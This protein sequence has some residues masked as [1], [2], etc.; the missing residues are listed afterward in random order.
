MAENINIISSTTTNNLDPQVPNDNF[1]MNIFLTAILQD[2]VVLNHLT[3]NWAGAQSRPGLLPPIRH[4]ITTAVENFPVIPP[5]A[6][7]RTSSRDSGR[8][9][10]S[11]SRV[12][13]VGDDDQADLNNEIKSR[14]RHL[15][16]VY[17]VSFAQLVVVLAIVLSFTEIEDV[18]EFR[19]TNPW[20]GNLSM[21]IM[22]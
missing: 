3:N 15:L 11:Q 16:K 8:L 1:D 19:K 6:A 20:I 9:T 7:T 2:D 18:K 4:K 12:T 21:G 5:I 22:I 10:R 14:N 13:A 17:I